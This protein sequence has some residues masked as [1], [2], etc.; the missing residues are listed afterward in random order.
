MKKRA[1][2]FKRFAYI[3][4][5]IELITLATFCIFY[6]SD[7]YNFKTVITP[8][9]FALGSVGLLGINIL[10]VVITVASA[11]TAR[12]KTD[13]RAAEVIGEDVQEAY[14]YDLKFEYLESHYQHFFLLYPL[15]MVAI[16]KCFYQ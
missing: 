8:Y 3:F 9:Y 15:K 5:I 4:A 14:N 12:Y 16:Q 11:T 7:L 6:F 10:L 2:R 1:Q 13:L